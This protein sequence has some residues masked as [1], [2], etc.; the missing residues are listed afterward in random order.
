MLRGRSLLRVR[1]RRRDSARSHLAANRLR[2]RSRPDLATGCRPLP[3]LRRRGSGSAAEA[4]R[5]RH[6]CRRCSVIAARAA[7]VTLG[8]GYAPPK[9]WK[10]R[11]GVHT[12]SK[13]LR[14]AKRAPL[15]QEPVAVGGGV[16]ACSEVE[17]AEARSVASMPPAAQGTRPSRLR[18]HHDRLEHDMEA[19]R[20]SP[21]ELEHRDVERQA[22]HREPDAGRIVRRSPGPSPR[23]SS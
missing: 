5:C 17:E 7:P 20:Q 14:S 8:F 22:R 21:Q 23:R 9:A 1:E 11:S 2:T 15:E 12:A 3:I 13:P 18:E 6:E 16:L 10:C 4:P 19:A